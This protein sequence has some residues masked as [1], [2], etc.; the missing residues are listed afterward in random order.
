MTSYIRDNSI[1][2]SPITR[3]LIMASEKFIKCPNLFLRKCHNPK[4]PHQ[5]DHYNEDWIAIAS[6]FTS[7]SIIPLGFECIV[8]S[9]IRFLIIIKY[10]Y[11]FYKPL[12]NI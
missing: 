9:I 5:S 10:V 11:K 2:L 1:L 7:D 4:L 12:F 6:L 3:N 8:M